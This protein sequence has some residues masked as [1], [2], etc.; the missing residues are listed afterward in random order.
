MLACVG[1]GYGDGST[2]YAGLSGLALLP[3]LLGFPPQTLPPTISS[4]TSPPSV[5]SQSTAALT[6]GLLHNS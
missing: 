2:P 5:S 6:L 4:L 3:W 1:R